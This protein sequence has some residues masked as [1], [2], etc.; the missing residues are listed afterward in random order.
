MDQDAENLRHILNQISALHLDSA[1]RTSPPSEPSRQLRPLRALTEQLKR[2]GGAP[3]PSPPPPA[4]SPELCD[5]ADEVLHEL[6]TLRM[7]IDS[8]LQF[9]KPLVTFLRTASQV[10]FLHPFTYVM[11]PAACRRRYNQST[12]ESKQDI[13]SHRQRSRIHHALHHNSILLTPVVLWSPGGAG[14]GGV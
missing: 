14:D 8:N 2:K 3:R 5:K 9:L 11:D 7:K 13:V 1:S 10:S 6:Q 4:L 12:S